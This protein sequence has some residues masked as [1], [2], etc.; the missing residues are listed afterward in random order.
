MRR[1]CSVVFGL[2]LPLVAAGGV[3]AAGLEFEGVLTGE[4][5]VPQF[6]TNTTGAVHI[7]FDE[8]FTEAQFVLEVFDGLAITQAHFHC[9]RAGQNGPVVMFLYGLGPTVDVDG[10]LSAATVTNANFTGADCVPQIGRPINNLAS[11]AFAM[12]DGLIYANVHTTVNPPGE[13]RGQLLAVE[14]GCDGS[15]DDDEDG[16]SGDGDGDGDDDKPAGQFNG[17]PGSKGMRSK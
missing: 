2:V 11:L 1:L 8:G 15:D 12:R 14:N 3:Q 9:N 4:Q 5:E 7:E 17:S 13:I 16:D 10:V 6:V